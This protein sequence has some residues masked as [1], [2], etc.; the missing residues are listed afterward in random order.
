M[1]APGEDER[2]VRMVREGIRLG[3]GD[4]LVVVPPVADADQQDPFPRGPGPGLGGERERGRGRRRRQR[5][6]GGG[7]GLIDHR[8]GTAAGRGRGF[9]HT[10]SSIAWS[11]KEFKRP[12]PP[13]TATFQSDLWGVSVFELFPSFCSNRQKKVPPPARTHTHARTQARAHTNRQ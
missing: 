7:G 1:M 8:E 11:P 9:I 10:L 13:F 5:R 2:A 12:R 6:T 4:K 3:Q